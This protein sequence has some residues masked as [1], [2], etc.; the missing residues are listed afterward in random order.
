MLQPLKFEVKALG[1]TGEVE[2]YASTYDLDEGGDQVVR[3]AFAK[4]LATKADGVP[5]L[6]SHDQDA[7][8]GR[9]DALT[10]NGRGLYVKGRLLLG[11]AKAK[12]TYELLRERVATG[13]SIGYKTVRSDRDNKTGTRLLREVDLYEISVVTFPMNTGARVIAVKSEEITTEREFERFLRDAGFAR[14]RAKLYT[15]KG[16]VPAEDVRRDAERAAVSDLARFIRERAETLMI[17]RS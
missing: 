14:E 10:E 8:I 6:W 17:R 16:F 3:G 13:L 12:E 1:D 11:L 15:S 9:W 5:M 2:G 7:P 4:S